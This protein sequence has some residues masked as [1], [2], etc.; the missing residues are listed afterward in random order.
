MGIVNFS[1]VFVVWFL[2]AILSGI[3]VLSGA[4]STAVRDN[5]YHALEPNRTQCMMPS[6]QIGTTFKARSTLDNTWIN[7]FSYLQ[8]PVF[9]PAFLTLNSII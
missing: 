4:E 8:T 5:V 7:T 6:L 3:A 2:S 1:G 9:P